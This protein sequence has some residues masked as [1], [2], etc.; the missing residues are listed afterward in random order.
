MRPMPAAPAAHTV[1]I[2]CMPAGPDSARL[3]RLV[4]SAVVTDESHAVRL[5]SAIAVLF[6]ELAD[7]T[8]A[9]WIRLDV[10][11]PPG[12][13]A[14]HVSAPDAGGDLLANAGRELSAIADAVA[15]AHDSVRFVMEVGPRREPPKG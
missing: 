10:E 5:R 7:P 1:A 12:A 3:A 6:A 13:V 11:R 9:R 8:G 14:V 15:V 4:G 2:L